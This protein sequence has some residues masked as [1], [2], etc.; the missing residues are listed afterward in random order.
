MCKSPKVIK[1]IIHE[2]H[3]PTATKQV[4]VFLLHEGI[5]L[6]AVVTVRRN[7]AELLGFS[8]SGGVN[9]SRRFCWSG[10]LSRWQACKVCGIPCELR[11]HVRVR[12]F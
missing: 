8:N 11:G 9:E 3:E 10:Y 5:D 4:A 1:R 12:E 6:V 7:V 2:M